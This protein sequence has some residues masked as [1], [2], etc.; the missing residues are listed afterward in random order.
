MTITGSTLLLSLVDSKDLF[1]PYM[2]DK[3]KNSD[4]LFTSLPITLTT[5]VVRVSMNKVSTV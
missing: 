2:A 3:G 1:R 4:A 5:I